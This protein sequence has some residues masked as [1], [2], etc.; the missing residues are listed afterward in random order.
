MYQALVAMPEPFPFPFP[1]PYLQKVTVPGLGAPELPS[2]PQR[3]PTPPSLASP[4]CT[5]SSPGMQP[6]GLLSWS[7]TSPLPVPLPALVGSQEGKNSKI[8]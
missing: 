6:S 1:H 2:V 5:G 4:T 3:A 8:P 7:Q